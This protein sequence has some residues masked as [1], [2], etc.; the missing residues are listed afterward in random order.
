MAKHLTRIETQT[1]TKK[2]SISNPP[3]PPEKPIYK[4]INVLKKD[5]EAIKFTSEVEKNIEE[6]KKK[7]EKIHIGK[8]TINTIE[9]DKVEI[10]KL[11]FQNKNCP[12]L[13][14]YYL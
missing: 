1:L 5:L 10:N 2:P 6:I 8:S 13:R 12:K 3:R 7:L 9:T 4:L 14:N 11:R